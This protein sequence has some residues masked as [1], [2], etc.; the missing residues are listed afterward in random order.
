MNE[1]YPWS[2][3]NAGIKLGLDRGL[4]NIAYDK[5]LT[6][7]E[8]AVILYNALTSEYLLG[9]TAPNGNVYYESTSIIEEIKFL[10]S[11]LFLS[12]NTLIIIVVVIY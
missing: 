10:K 11:S 7:A 4:E 3:I 5:T 6:R 12:T 2:Y 1:N 9:K 8:T